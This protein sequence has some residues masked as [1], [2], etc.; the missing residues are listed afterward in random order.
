M[1]C[2]L[3][4]LGAFQVFFLGALFLHHILVL[5]T[6]PLIKFQSSQAV[7]LTEITLGALSYRFL[8]PVRVE[9]IF[10]SGAE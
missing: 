4:E 2:T 7:P 5:V 8:H 3:H 9:G 6:Y 10:C 1:L